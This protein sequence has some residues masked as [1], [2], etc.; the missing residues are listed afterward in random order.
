MICRSAIALVVVVAVSGCDALPW[1]QVS[2]ARA[3]AAEALIDPSSAQFRSLRLGPTGTVCGEIN[4]KNRLGGY[5]GFRRFVV[6]Q[7]DAPILETD[8]PASIEPFWIAH[9]T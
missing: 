7:D 6:T 8:N 9:C 3:A 2:R 4:G 1:S 5:V